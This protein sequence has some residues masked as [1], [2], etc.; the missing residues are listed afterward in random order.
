MHFFHCYSEENSWQRMSL[1]SSEEE[2]WRGIICLKLIWHLSFSLVCSM[3]L[4]AGFLY[5]ASVLLSLP[6]VLSFSVCMQSSYVVLLFLTKVLLPMFADRCIVL[7]CCYSFTGSFCSSLKFWASKRIMD[8]KK[9]HLVWSG[10][11]EEI[12]SH[13]SFYLDWQFSDIWIDV[14]FFFN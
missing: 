7:L 11:N 5:T 6:L 12:V 9:L 3:K 8:L 14:P 2:L 1:W 13:A 10:P 4:L